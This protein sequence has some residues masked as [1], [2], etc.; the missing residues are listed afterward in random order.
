M[1]AFTYQALPT[2]VVFAAGALEQ[3]G[4]E[5][6]RLGACRVLVLGSAR[7][8]SSLLR[9]L[10]DRVVA[11]SD[12]VVMHVPVD[13]AE[14]ARALAATV[15]ADLVVAIGGGSATGLAKA[16]TLT[17]SL[18]IL[19]IPTTYAGSELT[20]IW[21]LT[22]DGAK[23]TGRDLRVLPRTVVYD[24]LLTVGLPIAS[25]ITSGLNSI[26]HCVESLYAEDAN[27]I[28]SL[29]AEAGLRTF[30][31]ALP[32]LQAEP[33][34]VGGR[35]QALYAAYLSGTVLGTVGMALHHKLCHTLGGTFGLPHAETHSVILPHAIAYNLPAA[36]EALAIVAAAFE[37]DN[38]A[39]ALW[40]FAAK[41]QAPM[42]LQSLGLTA[43][44][45]PRAA[46]IACEQPYWNPR[47]VVYDD[48]LTLLKNAYEGRRP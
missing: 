39:T 37:V 2:R 27:P 28:S 11:V 24:P 43:P 36:Q 9:I 41:L 12:N 47:P 48:I 20:P 10:G 44:D 26:A 30:A 5:V 35:T 13:V 7:H 3:V 40:D 8:S 31:Q 4:A 17:S 25:T 38:A 46:A 18:P 19:A 6:D 22:V 14:Q 23:K 33:H 16:V 42:S 1:L 21:G 45:L 29:L 34:N 15:Q 32:Q